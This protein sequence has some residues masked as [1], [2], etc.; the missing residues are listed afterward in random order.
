MF[1]K[2]F[3]VKSN[4]Q[5]KG[6]DKKKLKAE[7]RKKFPDFF[8]ASTGDDYDDMTTTQFLKSITY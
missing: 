2:P 5:M 1:A 3:R 4:T 6:S 8:S 7:V